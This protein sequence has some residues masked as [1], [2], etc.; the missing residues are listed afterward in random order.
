VRTLRF[1]VHWVGY[2]ADETSELSWSDLKRNK[3]MHLYLIENGLRHLIPKDYQNDY[4]ELS[5][6]HSNNSN[7]NT[8]NTSHVIET[9]SSTTT[10]AAIDQT[11]PQISSGAS[12]DVITNNNTNTELMSAQHDIDHQVNSDLFPARKR[13]RPRKHALNS[14]LQHDEHYV[15]PV[16][17]LSVVRSAVDTTQ[18]THTTTIHTSD[19]IL[20]RDESISSST[21]SS[22]SSSAD[23]VITSLQLESR[24]HLNPDL[25]DETLIGE[26]AAQSV[27]DPRNVASSIAVADTVDADHS[28]GEHSQDVNCAMEAL[29]QLDVD[30]VPLATTSNPHSAPPVSDAQEQ[31]TNKKR[32]RP[33]ATKNTSSSS[34]IDSS[35]DSG[36]DSDSSGSDG[37]DGDD[38]RVNEGSKKHKQHKRP[39][40]KI[41]RRHHNDNN[42][43]ISTNN[44]NATNNNPS[45]NNNNTIKRRKL[46]V[47]KS[48]EDIS[49]V[50]LKSG[51]HKRSSSAFDSESETDGIRAG[52]DGSSGAK[53]KQVMIYYLFY[54]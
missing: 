8:I 46:S 47:K 38:E 23:I 48:L 37:T 14:T 20:H 29:Q 16:V 34:D 49:N 5:S 7:N 4:S 41:A 15:A 25:T 42:T 30:C 54:Y 24:Q 3:V 35:S 18:A 11:S 1:T 43:N 33:I 45:D 13:G 9:T 39:P 12:D 50:F 51:V 31:P 17:A 44:N 28:G 26:S 6:P 22:S 32:S 52:R 27:V 53:R 36:S 10:S 19:S 2:S 40:R 21:S